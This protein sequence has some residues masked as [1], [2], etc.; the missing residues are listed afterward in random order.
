MI[1]LQAEDL[2]WSEQIWPLNT[3][4]SNTLP[5]ALNHPKVSLFGSTLW[6]L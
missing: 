4:T 3:S 6:A 1:A 5:T 2:G